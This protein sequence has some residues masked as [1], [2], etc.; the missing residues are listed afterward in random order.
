MRVD[1]RQV[2][3][4]DFSH[5]GRWSCGNG[6]HTHYQ[7]L[8]QQFERGAIFGCDFGGKSTET[9]GHGSSSLEVHCVGELR[10]ECA[11]ATDLFNILVLLR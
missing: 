6:R 9:A 4:Y 10:G 5:E 2:A 1:F 7:S 11:V 3:T 8:R